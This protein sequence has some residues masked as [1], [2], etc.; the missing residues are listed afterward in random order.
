MKVVM[1]CEFYNEALDFQENLL[2][3]YYGKHGHEV[4]VL[5]STF[6]SASVAPTRCL[7]CPFP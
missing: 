7:L 1:L 5:T 3:K 6:E 2:V 4:T